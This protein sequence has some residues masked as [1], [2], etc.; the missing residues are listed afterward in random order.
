MPHSL[1]LLV[2]KRLLSYDS[3]EEPAKRAF[4][5]V[6]RGL[7]RKG[8]EGLYGECKFSITSFRKLIL[9]QFP[10]ENL[11]LNI[12]AEPEILIGQA[13]KTIGKLIS[14]PIDVLR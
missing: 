1:M 10:M 11:A 14:K 2:W 13:L 9:I 4:Q 7:M 6:I 12:S 3:G 8:L 5:H